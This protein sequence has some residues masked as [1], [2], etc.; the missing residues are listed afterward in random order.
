MQEVHRERALAK[1]TRS[2]EVVGRRD[3]GYHLI[4]SEMVTLDFGDDLELCD[5]DEPEGPSG[6]EVVD[7]ISWVGATGPGDGAPPLA[8]PTGEENLVLRALA[9]LGRRARVRL[10][11]RIP[12][13]AGLGGGSADAAAVLRWAGVGDPLVAARLGADVPFCVVGGRALVGGIGEQLVQLEPDESCYVLLTPSLSVSTALVYRAF[14]EVGPGG[15][16]RNDLER[17][18]LVVEPRLSRWRDLLAEASGRVPVLA[19][20]GST[21][22]VACEGGE[23]PS[24]RAEVAAAVVEDRGRAAV[25]VGR[26]VGPYLR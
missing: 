5:P 25:N 9:V 17:A 2:L 6:L 23:A 10:S 1:L 19:G 13:G 12:P 11:K 3:D 15:P 14:D 22:Y 8:V 24:L 7:S 26:T 20:S 18:A 16:G 21:W 4:S